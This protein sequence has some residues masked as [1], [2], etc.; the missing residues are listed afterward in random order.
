MQTPEKGFALFKNDI[1]IFLKLCRALIHSRN[2]KVGS[3]CD[4][5]LWYHRKIR[6]LIA[7]FHCRY[8]RFGVGDFVSKPWHF[9]SSFFARSRQI[10]I[11]NVYNS[12]HFFLLSLYYVLL[13]FLWLFLRV[14]N[15]TFPID[16]RAIFSERNLD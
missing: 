8:Q 5:V 6:S 13:Y 7:L 2:Q 15:S 14:F 9:G 3:G 10:S 16:Y 4:I 11:I 1:T 12:S